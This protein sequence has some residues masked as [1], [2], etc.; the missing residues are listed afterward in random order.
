MK[1]LSSPLTVASALCLA[2][3]LTIPRGQ[4]AG[5]VHSLTA[6]TAG[7]AAHAESTHE[8][9]HAKAAGKKHRHHK[10]HGKK[11]GHKKHL[12]KARK[13][14]R[15]HG[16]KS[17]CFKR[18][19]VAGLIQ[20]SVHDPPAGPP[21]PGPGAGM[22]HDS[23]VPYETVTKDG[24]FMVD[25]VK[26]A[27]FEHGDKFGNNHDQYNQVK[28]RANVSIVRYEAHIA[29]EDRVLMTHTKCFEFCRTVPAMN[30]FGLKDGRYCYCMPYYSHLAADSSNCDIPCEG[31]PEEMCGGNVKSTVFEMHSCND[32]VVKIEEM[33][34]E[35]E[36]YAD[37]L[38]N[39][40]DVMKNI[41]E[42]A[43][44]HVD[45]LQKIFQEAGDPDT[46]ALMQDAKVYIGKIEKVYQNAQELWDGELEDLHDTL[47]SLL[48]SDLT[49]SDNL[50]ASERAQEGGKKAIEKTKD[51]INELDRLHKEVKPFYNMPHMMREDPLPWEDMP[52]PPAAVSDA[53]IQ[54]YP[55]L[56]FAGQT[57]A[58]NKWMNASRAFVHPPETCTGELHSIIF[59]A[60]V[61]DCAES[62]DAA[63][64]MCSA[65]QYFAYERGYCF[66]FKN[67]RLLTN[68]IGCDKEEHGP[69]PFAAQ[70]YAKVQHYNG[71]NVSPR[72]D[73]KIYQ[74]TLKEITEANHRCWETPTPGC[75]PGHEDWSFYEYVDGQPHSGTC[76]EAGAQPGWCQWLG[77]WHHWETDAFSDDGYTGVWVW[78]TAIETCEECGFCEGERRNHGDF[79]GYM[80]FY[81]Y[82]DAE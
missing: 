22:D 65:F 18:R 33:R 60:T 16:H 8:V 71:V 64:G 67:V 42:I 69:A 24:F 63:Q 81:E 79:T 1:F 55:F 80:Y 57:P 11:L 23:I 34:A 17:D 6:A 32:A 10:H 77:G 58:D 52:E 36:D 14:D 12:G 82:Y 50:I 4:P 53:T 72:R 40:I 61:Q 3:G 76:A 2:S 29:K 20:T 73:G 27:L 59:H 35:L 74:D 51:F 54:Y 28:L 66:L 43:E 37:Q 25:C 70:C 7:H 26:D 19:P 39:H 15:P 30:Y 44:D 75:L 5:V 47:G 38:E 45:E 78:Q 13:H 48:D 68:W 46:S 9:Q 49:Q 31:N 62:C 21:A 56:Y 41:C